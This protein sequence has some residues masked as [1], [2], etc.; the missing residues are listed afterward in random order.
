MLYFNLRMH[1][2]VFW[3]VGTTFH[4]VVKNYL[5]VEKTTLLYPFSAKI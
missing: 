3:D 5:P 4:V 1:F 2:E